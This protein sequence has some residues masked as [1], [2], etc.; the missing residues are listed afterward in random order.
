MQREVFNFRSRRDLLE[1][2]TANAYA[3]RCRTPP[4][5]ARSSGVVSVISVALLGGIDMAI[6]VANMAHTI[7]FDL[8]LGYK[9]TPSR[10]PE[11]IIIIISRK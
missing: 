4:F 2:L 8:G 5:P 6:Y 11:M 10:A 3:L 7:S 1:L 9:N